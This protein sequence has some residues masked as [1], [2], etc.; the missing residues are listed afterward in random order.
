MLRTHTTLHALDVWRTYADAFD[1]EILIR[2]GRSE[3]GVRIIR[4]A[5]RSL[6]SGGFI[7]YATA[8]EGVLAEGL[9]AAGQVTEAREIV[10]RAIGQCRRSGEAWCLPELMRVEALILTTTGQSSEAVGLLRDGLRLARTQGV[11]AWERKLAA[12]LVGVDA[13]VGARRH[14][15]T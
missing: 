15:E 3:E 9:L 14:S 8:F 5:L 13:S 1:G 2:R 10:A 6:K 7:L 4:G 12:A 11:L